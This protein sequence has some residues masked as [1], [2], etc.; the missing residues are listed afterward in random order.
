MKWSLCLGLIGQIYDRL[1]VEFPDAQIKVDTWKYLKVEF[2]VMREGMILSKRFCFV[3]K[4]LEM[5][6]K[7]PE[8]W[9]AHQAQ[10]VIREFEQQQNGFSLTG[11]FNYE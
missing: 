1:L 8:D 3:P 10:L 6:G 11:G 5:M 7:L 9:A 2:F 4:E